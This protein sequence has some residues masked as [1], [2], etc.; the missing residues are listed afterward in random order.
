MRQATETDPEAQAELALCSEASG[1]V[2]GE[3]ITVRRPY[4]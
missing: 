4:S 2:G 3:C 1:R